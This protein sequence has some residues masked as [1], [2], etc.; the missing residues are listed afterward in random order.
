MTRWGKGLYV[1]YEEYFWHI[2]LN[3]TGWWMPGNEEAAKATK[4]NEIHENFLH[5]INPKN[6]RMKMFLDDGQ[7]W[8]YHDSRTWGKWYLHQ[9]SNWL[10]HKYLREQGP[11]WFLLWESA[12][13]TLTNHQSNKRTKDVLCDQR[14]TAGLGNYLACEICFLTMVHP[15]V[16]WD[17]LSKETKNYLALIVRDFLGLCASRSDHTHWNVFKK[18]G[19]TCPRCQRTK[20]EYVKDSDSRGSYFCP[21][22]QP[23]PRTSNNV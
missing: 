16:K 12:I 1:L 10:E 20:I 4:I 3:S 17:D 15:H 21:A 23:K 13:D 19:E 5:K 18:L 11:D 2:H 22:C 7:I 14:V 6:V 8:F 9:E